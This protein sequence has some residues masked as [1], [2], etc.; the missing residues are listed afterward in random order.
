LD[1]VAF[2]VIVRY[3]CCGA[4]D[5][6]WPVSAIAEWLA[7]LSMAEYTERFAEDDIDF[8]VLGELT[9]H[10]FDRLG[11]IAGGC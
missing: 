6:R 7:S 11:V 1:G 5:R 10:D 9:D 8:D 4:P 3:V 2:T